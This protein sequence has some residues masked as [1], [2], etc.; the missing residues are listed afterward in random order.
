MTTPAQQ[1]S[2]VTC[3]TYL[4][5]LGYPTYPV[6]LLVLHLRSDL[7][8]SSNLSFLHRFKSS[9]SELCFYKTSP[10]QTC[11]K[12]GAK[13]PDHSVLSALPVVD[14][15]RV[16]VELNPPESRQKTT[17]R[18]PPNTTTTTTAQSF[19]RCRN[20]P[21]CPSEVLA[22]DSLPFFGRLHVTMRANPLIINWHD[23]SQP[24]Y[25]AHFEPSGKG[26]LA[27]AAGDTNV[28]VRQHPGIVYLQICCSSSDS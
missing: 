18:K 9:A 15:K 10:L 3:G 16:P 8:H 1:S 4:L 25:S 13:A 7:Q 5:Y 24:I 17:S 28:R 27:T 2:T 6:Y 19:F 14:Q 21:S 22:C 11:S 26:R 20:H 23:Q 12:L